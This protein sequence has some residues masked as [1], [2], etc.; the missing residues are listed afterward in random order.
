MPNGTSNTK[1]VIFVVLRSQST[2]NTFSPDLKTN[3]IRC[4]AVSLLAPTC[5][6]CLHAG[7]KMEFW[8][9]IS[10]GWKMTVKQ[11][12]RQGSKFFSQL[13]H[14]LT[15][16]HTPK[17]PCDS[18]S[19]INTDKR[20]MLSLPLQHV[21]STWSILG[22]HV[23]HHNYFYSSGSVKTSHHQKKCWKKSHIGIQ[24]ETKPTSFYWNNTQTHQ[25]KGS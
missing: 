21:S 24:T 9:C 12:A 15:A 5:S 25:L 23:R 20:T 22:K 4:A 3:A 17:F 7:D 14:W 19:P 2:A 18:V 13:W 16:W 6:V 8:T 11:T 10:E 1:W